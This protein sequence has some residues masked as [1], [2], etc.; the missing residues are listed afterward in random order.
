MSHVAACLGELAVAKAF[1][2]F[3]SGSVGNKEAVD[4]GDILEV[5]SSARTNARLILHPKDKDDFPFVLV[6]VS[7]APIIH[8][9]GWIMGRDGKQRKYWTDPAGGRPAYFI[10]ESHLRPMADL[11]PIVEV[12]RAEIIAKKDEAAA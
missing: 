11:R 10:S 1:N 7:T 9:R 2:L 5:R 4:V 8:L 6:D 12:R 3:C